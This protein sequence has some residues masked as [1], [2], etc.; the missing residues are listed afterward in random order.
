M[1]AM[2]VCLG[3]RGG[4]SP[5]F[6]AL[7]CSTV[8][9]RSTTAA[10]PSTLQHPS[11]H[12][13]H[14]D[15]LFVLIQGIAPEKIP[16]GNGHNKNLLGFDLSMALIFLPNAQVWPFPAAWH[17]TGKAPAEAGCR[18][19]CW[20]SGLNLEKALVKKRTSRILL[21]LFMPRQKEMTHFSGLWLVSQA[22]GR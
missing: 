2:W 14:Q 9:E 7:Q 19:D 12:P 17:S 6:D 20:S 3:R 22:L 16:F 21:W 11:C 10:I 8:L 4:S 13:I 1:P 5:V 15:R 18:A